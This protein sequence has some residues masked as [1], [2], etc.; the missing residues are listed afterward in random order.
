[1]DIREGKEKT[2]PLGEAYQ[3]HQE[4][5]FKL[6]PSTFCSIPCEGM[7]PLPHVQLEI[8]CPRAYSIDENTISQVE[9][10][11][12]NCGGILLTILRLE[13]SNSKT[14]FDTIQ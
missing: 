8:N 7:P 10:Q 11:W 5:F 6:P 2:S 1:M 12:A 13:A 9:N 4:G 14:F 3:N